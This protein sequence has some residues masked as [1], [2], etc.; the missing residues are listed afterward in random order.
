M[1]SVAF[2]GLGVAGVMGGLLLV[3]MIS[4]AMVAGLVAPWL[5]V[6]ARAGRRR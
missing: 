5:L 2:V 3:L 4:A 6:R 1:N